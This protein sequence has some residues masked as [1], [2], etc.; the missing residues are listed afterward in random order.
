MSEVELDELIEEE[1][2]ASSNEYYIIEEI[3]AYFCE[4][5][6]F[7]KRE[8]GFHNMYLQGSSFVS[9]G[10]VA[11]KNVVVVF[12]KKSLVH[13]LPFFSDELPEGYF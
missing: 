10:Y 7:L 13:S 6:G 11:D 9:V 3:E 4:V 5:K 2:P 12:G 8:L 1:I